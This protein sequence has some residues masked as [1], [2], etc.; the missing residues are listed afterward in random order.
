MS[1]WKLELPDCIPKQELRNE[2]KFL[3]SSIDTP[4]QPQISNTANPAQSRVSNT[5]HKEQ[6]D[7][8]I[9]LY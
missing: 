8:G 9:A 1:T 7:K 6:Y 4:S 2:S 3:R 5:R